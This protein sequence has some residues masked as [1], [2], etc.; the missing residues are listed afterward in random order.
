MTFSDEIP[1]DDKISTIQ[2]A[3]ILNTANKDVIKD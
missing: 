3:N 1:L 2:N